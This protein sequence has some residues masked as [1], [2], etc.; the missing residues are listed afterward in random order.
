[1]IVRS[2]RNLKILVIAALALIAVAI[3]ARIPWGVIPAIFI[4]NRLTREEERELLYNINHEVLASELRSF[5]NQKR[6]SKTVP[7]ADS[8]CFHKSDPL[9]ASLLIL[10]PSQICV[11]DDRVEY[12]CGGPFLSFGIAVF[13][14]G[15]PGH[16][17]KKLGEGIWFYAEDGRV[18]AQ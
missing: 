1:M 18:P 6:W 14:K 5:A 13:R 11:F 7:S 10:N 8:D 9:P 15:I 16:G 3:C 4:G 17:T 12:D 2:R